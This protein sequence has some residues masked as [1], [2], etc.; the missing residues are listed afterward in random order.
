[1]DKLK[2]KNGEWWMCKSINTLRR[3]PMIK[4]DGGWGSIQNSEGKALTD[5]VQRDPIITP[6]YK[7]VKA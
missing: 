3:C 5:F 2:P 7:M 6:V 4:V 1:M